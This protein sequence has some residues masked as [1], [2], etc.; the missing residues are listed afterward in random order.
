MTLLSVVEGP[1]GAGGLQSLGK[2]VQEPS[3]L[4][5]LHE[6]YGTVEGNETI[7]VDSVVESDWVAMH[8]VFAGQ[9]SAEFVK[10]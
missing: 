8:L 9:S 4:G 1:P 6:V 2:A 10:G 3:R 5:V 7:K